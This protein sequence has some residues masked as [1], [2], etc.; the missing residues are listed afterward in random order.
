MLHLFVVLLGFAVFSWGAEYKYSLYFSPS[1]GQAQVAPAKLLS[2]KER[3]PQSERAGMETA[4]SKAPIALTFLA[5]I[6]A[7]SASQMFFK[8][9]EAGLVARPS[10][11]CASLTTA[12]FIHFAFRPPPAYSR[13]PRF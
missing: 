11:Q 13:F 12:C 8:L 3:P 4:L 7:A 2:Q 6:F 5:F 10:R 9:R 1:Q